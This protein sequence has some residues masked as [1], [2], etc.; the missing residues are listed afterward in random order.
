MN[1]PKQKKASNNLVKPTNLKTDIKNAKIL[2]SFSSIEKNEYF[3][4]DITCQNW[5]SDLFKTMKTVSNIT[6]GEIDAGKYSGHGSPLR[7]HDHSDAKP[8]C[9]L[10][11]GVELNEFFQ[12]R[13]SSS[14]GGVHGIFVDN[15]FY[16]FWFDPLHNMYPDKKYGGLKVVTPPKTCCKDMEDTIKKQNAIIE[17]LQIYKEMYEEE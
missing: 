8:P 9:K 10:P 5:A 1:I 14:K 16:V 2:F 7:I 4:L 12:I 6:K 3:D 11:E 13:I 17:E 15:I